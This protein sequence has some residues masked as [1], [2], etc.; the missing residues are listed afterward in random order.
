MVDTVFEVTRF[1]RHQTDQGGL[2]R[3]VRD[4]VFGEGV[5]YGADGLGCCAAFGGV[6]CPLA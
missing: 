1:V 5:G 3:P 6:G 4:V 2:N